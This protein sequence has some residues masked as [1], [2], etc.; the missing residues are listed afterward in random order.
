MDD[1]SESAFERV[2]SIPL[3]KWSAQK[4]SDAANAAKATADRYIPGSGNYIDKVGSATASSTSY[5]GEKLGWLVGDKV[6]KGAN[7]ISNKGLD[8]VESKYPVINKPVDELPDY[9]KQAATNKLFSYIGLNK[10][11]VSEN[12]EQ[13][14]KSKEK[15]DSE[16]F[17]LKSTVSVEMKTPDGTSYEMRYV[18]FNLK[19]NFMYK[20]ITNLWPKKE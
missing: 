1:K 17:S 11:K 5:V 2:K 8:M 13:T 14:K 18:P 3:I 9:S 20:T 4:T 6:S 10:S 16:S 12:P 7:D 15:E 19:D